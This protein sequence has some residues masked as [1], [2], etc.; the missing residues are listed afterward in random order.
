[1]AVIWKEATQCS[2]NTVSQCSEM[3]TKTE[4]QMTHSG[5]K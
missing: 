2:A 4:R 3:G 1:M 5:D